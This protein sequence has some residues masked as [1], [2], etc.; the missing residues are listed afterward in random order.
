MSVFT[1]C[2]TRSEEKAEKNLAP[3]TARKKLEEL[4][5]EFNESNFLSKC[6]DGNAETVRLFIA[7]GMSP[8]VTQS[9]S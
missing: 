7:A 6:S 9:P 1:S 5:I 4:K 3:E 2:G 8:I